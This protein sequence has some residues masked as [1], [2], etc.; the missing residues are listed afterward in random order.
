QQTIVNNKDKGYTL[1]LDMGI[2]WMV[3]G[4]GLLTHGG[5]GP[6]I[7][8]DLYLYPARGFAAA[9]L[10]NGGNGQSLINEFM[11]PWLKELGAMKPLGAG[12]VRL[13]SEPVKIDPDQYVGVY[14]DVA[15][16]HRVSRTP[17]GLALSTQ[18]KVALYDKVS[19]WADT[20]AT[21]P[22]RL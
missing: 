15:V 11:E 8:S 19:K 1:D 9:I 2:G 14:E 3:S 12:N 22:A 5:G 7:V 13:P 6:G 16:R 21:P 17:D 10:T 18:S 20:E 4:D